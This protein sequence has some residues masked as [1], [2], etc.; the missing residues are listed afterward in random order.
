LQFLERES[1]GKKN[2]SNLGLVYPLIFLYNTTNIYYYNLLLLPRRGSM[3][4]N[5]IQQVLE[6]EKQAQGIHDLAVRDAQQV[7]IVADQEAQAILEKA[8]A[9]AH[10]EARQL[11]GKAQ[12]QEETDRILAQAEEKSRQSEAMAMSNFDRAVT[13]ILDR[14]INRD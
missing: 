2:L 13:Y 3:N 4:E 5:R 7:P 6:I 8:R 10:E 12:A 11:V 14:I 1:F 9:G